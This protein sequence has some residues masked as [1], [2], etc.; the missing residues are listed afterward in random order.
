[1]LK[2]EIQQKLTAHF[3]PTLLEVIDNSAAHAGH[4]AEDA[5]HYAIKII[6]A[7][8]SG[9]SLVQRHRAIYTVLQSELQQ[10]I[11]ALQ[12]TALAPEEQ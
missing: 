8:F 4:Q 1:M 2:D 12:L 3:T 11:H 6:S 9:L 5:G 7:Q 10:K